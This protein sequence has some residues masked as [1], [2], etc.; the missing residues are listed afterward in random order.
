VPAGPRASR[1]SWDRVRA[2]REWRTALALPA[3]LLVL[4]LRAALE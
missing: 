4:W 1:F 3:V 2:N